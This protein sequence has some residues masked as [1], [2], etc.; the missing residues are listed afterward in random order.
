[1]YFLE[2]LQVRAA[3]HGGVLYS[4]DIDGMLFEFFMNFL[5][6]EKNKILRILFSIFHVFFAFH[7]ISNINF[8]FLQKQ[9]FLISRFM[10]FST[11][12]KYSLTG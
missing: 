6:I 3:C 1:M 10:L 5:N 12:T 7:A 9:L 8:F 11:L 4:F 2:T